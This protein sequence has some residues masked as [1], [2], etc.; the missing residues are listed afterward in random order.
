MISISLDDSA[1]AWEKACAEEEIPW[2]SL[3]NPDGFKNEGIVPLLGIKA[4]PFIVTVDKE[5]KIVA[6][7]LRRN[8]LR[9]KVEELL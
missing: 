8:L 9:K 1:T 3:R 5:G 2:M 4:I 7:G 6:K